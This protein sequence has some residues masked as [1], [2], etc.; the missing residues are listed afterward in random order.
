MRMQST[1]ALF[2][3]AMMIATPAVA[4]DLGKIETGAKL[5]DRND[6]EPIT[7]PPPPPGMGQVVFWRQGGGGPLVRCRVNEGE[8]MV[9]R[10]SSGS[11]FATVV[12]PGQHEYS[13]RTEATDVLNLE[14]EPDETQ[15][16]RCTIRMGLFIGRPNLSPSDEEAFQGR[17]HRMVWRVRDDDEGRVN[18]PWA[19]NLI[20]DDTPEE[21]D[22]EE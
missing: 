13:V 3:A 15:Y 22:G 1:G 9:G 18:P 8:T 5:F 4:G 7:V 21:E 11:Y 17:S 14:V 16:V 19:A 20:G 2:F 12:E 10:L 6:G